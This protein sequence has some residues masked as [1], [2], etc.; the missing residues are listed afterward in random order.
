[1]N[2]RAHTTIGYLLLIILIF[3]FLEFFSKTTVAIFTISYIFAL[4]MLSPDLDTRSKIYNNWGPGR[5]LWYP[6]QKTNRHRGSSHT[7]KGSFLRV[8]YFT[9][10]L[11]AIAILV[12]KI[13]GRAVVESLKT[14]NTIIIIFV[15][16]SLVASYQHIIIDRITAKRRKV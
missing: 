1:M 8:V 14:H 16:A 12:F 13:S 11:T 3:I 9:A 7:L 4:H 5:V 6:Y 15:V 10:I 2:Y